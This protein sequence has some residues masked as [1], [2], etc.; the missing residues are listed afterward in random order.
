[1]TARAEYVYRMPDSITDVHAAPLLCA[2]AIGYR[3]LRLTHLKD[4]QNLGLMG[5]GSSAHL[6]LKMAR[7]RLP[8]SRVFV[9]ARGERSPAPALG[10]D[11][12]ILLSE[13]GVTDAE[14]SILAE[15]KIIVTA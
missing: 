15:R 14:I 7:H 9:F 4:G 11:T 3:S 1:M 13:I 8:G 5:F 2:G 6:V 10:A 12:R